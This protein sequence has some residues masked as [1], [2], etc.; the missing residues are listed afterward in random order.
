[1]NIGIR[2]H[3]TAPGTL[4]ERA[5]AAAAQGFTC[6][7]VALYK[8]LSSAPE[9]EAF[10]PALAKALKCDLQPLNIAILGCYLNLAHPD[11]EIYQKT[12]EQYRAH[13]RMSAWIGG[14]VVGTETGNPNAAYRY[15]PAKSHTPEALALFI[16]RLRPVVAEAERL[17]TT[18]AIEPVYTHIVHDPQ[19]ARRVLDA[20]AS[21]SLKIILDPVN[22]LHPDNLA[23]RDELLREA[24]ELLGPDIAA[25]HLK[26]YVREGGE[27]RTV[28]S[29][30]GETDDLPVL[31]YVVAHKPDIPVLLENTSPQN[32]AEARAHVEALAEAARQSAKP[33]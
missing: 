18:V 19:T 2:L 31:R 26:D 10:S 9:A 32:A 22:L 8:L 15:D 23:R 25:V 29:G 16:R 33:Y 27:L 14:C 28:P 5:A 21:P 6:A 13:L 30:Q 3:D 20:L 7:H 12:L 17:Q 11:E 1:M 4:T 24:V